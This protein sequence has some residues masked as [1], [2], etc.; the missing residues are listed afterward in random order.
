MPI[1]ISYLHTVLKP[2]QNKGAPFYIMPF[3]VVLKS[4]WRLLHCVTIFVCSGSSSSKVWLY[5]RHA[6]ILEQLNSPQT[7]SRKTRNNSLLLQWNMMSQLGYILHHLS[8]YLYC[9]LWKCFATLTIH[10]M[11]L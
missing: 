3:S 7:S 2:M 4:L 9:V 8:R 10:C 6:C 1:E 5:T 11:V